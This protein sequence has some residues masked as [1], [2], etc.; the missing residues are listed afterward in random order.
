MNAMLHQIYNHIALQ[1]M[2]SRV[3]VHVINTHHIC[4]STV[5]TFPTLCLQKSLQMDSNPTANT[6]TCS[7]YKQQKVL[8]PSQATTCLRRGLDI[9]S[10][11]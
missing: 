8:S 6:M 3:P 5:Y 1:L 2:L 11:H 10:N 9:P 4:R 7:R